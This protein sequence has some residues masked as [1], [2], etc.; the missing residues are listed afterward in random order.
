MEDGGAG[1]KGWIESRVEDGGWRC[2]LLVVYCMLYV[3][4]CEALRVEGH[5]LLLYVI[6][7]KQ[8]CTGSQKIRL[9]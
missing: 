7:C 1:W 3:G 5:Y 2:G 9:P 8:S 4:V 6:V